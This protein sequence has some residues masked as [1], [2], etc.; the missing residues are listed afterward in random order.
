MQT[1]EK[2]VRRGVYL[3]PNALTTGAL[4][5]GFYS[6]I[7]GINSHYVAAAIAVGV[8][9]LITI[10]PLCASILLSMTPSSLIC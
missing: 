9:L 6:I 10:F 7:A 5:A 3:L 2:K 1:G 8:M 4:F